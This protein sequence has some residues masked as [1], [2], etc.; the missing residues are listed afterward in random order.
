MHYFLP[1][2]FETTEQQH[3]H[4]VMWAMSQLIHEF[5]LQWQTQDLR[6]GFGDQSEM[7]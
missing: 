5:I 4:F 2:K 3:F 7:K 1:L 6:R